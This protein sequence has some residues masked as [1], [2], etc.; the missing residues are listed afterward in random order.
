MGGPDEGGIPIMGGLAAGLTLISVI[1][2][3]DEGGIPIFGGLK[4]FCI[5]LILYNEA[6]SVIALLSVIAG[7]L[8]KRFWASISIFKAEKILHWDIIEM[9]SAFAKLLEKNPVESSHVAF[10]AGGNG[11]PILTRAS[12]Q[13]TTGYQTNGL[14][15][16]SKPMPGGGANRTTLGAY[17][18]G[19]SDGIAPPSAIY[20]GDI[21]GPIGQPDR[22][23]PERTFANVGNNVFQPQNDDL[24][25]HALLKRLGDQQFKAVSQAPFED[26]LAQQ[27]LARDLNEASRNASLSDLGTSREILRNMAA[28]RRQQNEDDFLRKMLDSGATPEAA[29]KEIQ[30]VRNANAIQEARKVEDRGYQAKMLIQ[31]L[32]I[33][34]GVTPNV[35]EPLNYSSSIDN[36]QRSQAMSQ[37][38]GMP[39]EGFGTSDLDV[40]RQFLTPDFYRKFLRRSMLTQEAGDEQQAFNQS[41]AEGEL[42]PPSQG[43]FSMATLKGQQRQMQIENASE[44]LAARL[45]TIR[46]RANRLLL[47]LPA[48][49][50]S[51]EFLNKL[52]ESKGR[53]KSNRV[54]HSVET[55]QDM[56]PL[57]LLIALNLATISNPDGLA[58]LKE[59]IS[60][61]GSLGTADAP[62]PNVINKLKE[63]VL[64]MNRGEPNISIP[65]VSSVMSVPNSKIVTILQD[66]RNDNTET[67]SKEIQ[68]AR[69]EYFREVDT[70]EIPLASSEIIALNRR[71]PTGGAASAIAAVPIP[72]APNPEYN[73]K[74]GR[75]FMLD[76][77]KDLSNPGEIK[78]FVRTSK[79]VRTL[80]RAVRSRQ[81]TAVSDTMG[82]LLNEVEM[83]S[84]SN[85][86]K[87]QLIEELTA[88]GL[89][90]NG[91][92]K[93][94]LLRLFKQ[95]E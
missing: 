17:R 48:N 58:K 29:Q 92:K 11:V 36:P 89:S 56:R 91:T 85:M 54:L 76:A 41:I 46:S 13:A 87:P 19:E 35:Q 62:S 55:I 32:A 31:R 93:Q 14:P 21:F 73:S 2:R 49:V 40:N 63:I 30:D 68:K 72:G 82:G 22:I 4:G 44:A 84:F 18:M 53:T 20:S 26:Y 33:R 38:M 1:G 3:P 59:A 86:T 60:T 88:K 7:S 71:P 57:Q 5:P 28:E 65:F 94:L 81:R 79:A 66:I 23:N 6:R 8:K 80:Q 43:A 51:K 69:N 42:Q 77:I 25:T 52:Y 24:A 78:E 67:L 37:A 16:G 10:R 61:Q 39:G 27:R 12:G 34:R 15:D 47:P 9:K 90:T 75:E 64:E 83:T 95:F 45:E 50:I 70:S 74:A